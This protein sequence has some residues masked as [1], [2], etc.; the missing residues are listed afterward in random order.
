MSALLGEAAEA[1]AKVANRSL[2]ALRRDIECHPASHSF[3]RMR[4][5][6]RMD[7]LGDG[8]RALFADEVLL[9]DADADP[10]LRRLLSFVQRCLPPG[11]TT[12]QAAVAAVTKVVSTALGSSGSSND[13]VAAEDAAEE[14]FAKRIRE[15]RLPHHGE[16]PVGLVFG[17]GL[18]R[19]KAVLLKYICDELRLCECALVG[20]GLLT[21]R[22]ADHLK[23]VLPLVRF[24]DGAP[25]MLV[26]VVN[27]PGYMEQASD[28]IFGLVERAEHERPALASASS[29]PMS[30]SVSGPASPTTGAS[31]SVGEWHAAPPVSAVVKRAADAIAS[32]VQS[33]DLTAA[34]GRHTTY[35]SH[36]PLERERR[37]ILEAAFHEV[38]YSTLALAVTARDEQDGRLRELVVVVPDGAARS[39]NDLPM[40]LVFGTCQVTGNSLSPSE[41]VEIDFKNTEVEG[42][43]RAWKL[44]RFARAAFEQASGDEP[45]TSGV[46]VRIWNAEEMRYEALEPPSGARWWATVVDS[47]DLAQPK[48]ARKMGSRRRKSCC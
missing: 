3:H 4:V 40:S 15:L 13:D 38:R 30:D 12:K 5:L 37:P 36:R 19:H 48:L 6:T 21:G 31:P 45:T 16:L 39:V 25:L 23:T 14:R 22:G 24:E 27:R 2:A 47:L 34:C 43:G 7:R 29:S 26:D 35:V 11:G 46:R 42:E 18:Q 8:F 41:C 28:E 20:G 9:V 32:A 44:A 17:C 33:L 1:P 10:A